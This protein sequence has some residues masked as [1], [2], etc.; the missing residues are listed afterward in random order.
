VSVPHNQMT[1][2]PT[3]HVGCAAHTNKDD[4]SI[5]FKNNYDELELS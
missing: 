5:N 4:I 1:M 2:D 3:S